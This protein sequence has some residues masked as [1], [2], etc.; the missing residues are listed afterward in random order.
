VRAASALVADAVYG[1]RV[2]PALAAAIA[3]DA[4]LRIVSQSGAPRQ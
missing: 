3:R 4:L 2:R 1:T